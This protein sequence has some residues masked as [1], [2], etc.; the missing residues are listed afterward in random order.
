MPLW[1]SKS[2]RRYRELVAQTL[3]EL[4]QDQSYEHFEPPIYY[5][6]WLTLWEQ[7]IE[8]LKR[9]CE[10][11]QL[12]TDTNYFDKQARNILVAFMTRVAAFVE[13]IRPDSATLQHVEH[14]ASYAQTLSLQHTEIDLSSARKD[15]RRM[16]EDY[17]KIHVETQEALAFVRTGKELIHFAGPRP[18]TAPEW[19]QKKSWLCST[20]LGVVV[21]CTRVIDAAIESQVNE[22][23]RAHARTRSSTIIVNYLET[24]QRSVTQH[25]SALTE[26]NVGY[27][28]E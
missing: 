19:E 25:F 7:K 10:A 4:S 13:T 3:Q 27:L 26:L 16:L 11:E 15:Y 1:M 8:Q 23:A 2:Q 14:F 17:E 18:Y 24:V 9:F 21:A 6:A 22:L 5:G 28:H 20:L 12:Q